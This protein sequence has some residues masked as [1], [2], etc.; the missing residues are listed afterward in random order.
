MKTSY[1]SVFLYAM[2]DDYLHLRKCY[3]GKT[4]K[5]DAFGRAAKLSDSEI[6]YVYVLA[7]LDYG[8]NYAKSMR[9]CY[10][11]GDIKQRLDKS[12]FG[13]RLNKLRSLIEELF[14]LLVSLFALH[15]VTYSVDTCPIPVCHNIRIPRCHLVEGEAYRGY[16]ASKR[17]FYFG[18]KLHALVASNGAMV[19]FDFTPASY[20]DQET[21]HLLAFDLPIGSELFADAIYC[22][23][24]QEERL[25]EDLQL[26][27][28][29]QRKRNSKKE[30]NTY[31]HNQYV[32]INRKHIETTFSQ[33]L[34]LF[35]RK[36][37]ATNTKGFL[38]KIVGFI[39]AYNFNLFSRSLRI[40]NLFC[41]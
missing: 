30:D 28:Q 5:F 8:G 25:V 2:I 15:N 34:N 16:C 7:C 14:A 24:Q 33:M 11:N 21:L 4:S 40:G 36:V 13:R 35:P 38:L 6:L 3:L 19:A 32:Q 1:K 31:L 26:N 22:D 41:F 37:H 27:F 29:P 12:Q 9:K 10:E 18:F 17:V 23:Y 20:S 39:F